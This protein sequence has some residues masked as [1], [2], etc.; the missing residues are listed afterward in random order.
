[1]GLSGSFG[2]VWNVS[3]KVA[4]RPE[5]Y[6]AIASG[7]ADASS[8]TS[9][10][11]SSS[12]RWSVGASAL[13]YV[14]RRDNLSAYLSPLFSYSRSKSNIE[15]GSGM[16]MSSDNTMS[17]YFAS[18]SLGLQYALNRRFG[19]F[20]E[21]GIGYSNQRARSSSHDVVSPGSSYHAW[22]TR[23]AVGAVWYF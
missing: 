18:V 16:Q 7:R 15:E 19:V 9:G 8:L 6:L 20:G 3:E 10:S 14:H 22:G 21:V 13:F 2:L 5:F 11:A 23:T 12:T 17:G 1:V 4:L